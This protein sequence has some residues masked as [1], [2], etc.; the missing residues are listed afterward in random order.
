SKKT[1]ST[2]NPRR[3]MK[4]DTSDVEV[5]GLGVVRD[6]RR[7]GLLR[8]ELVLLR[9]RDPDPLGVEQLEQLHLILEVGAGGVA[10]RVAAALDVVLEHAVERLVAADAERGA[11]AG[12]PVLRERLGALDRQAVQL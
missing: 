4:P 8:V 6:Q 2:Q 9:Q 10:E 11:D 12:V 5:L 3:P 7:G 1:A